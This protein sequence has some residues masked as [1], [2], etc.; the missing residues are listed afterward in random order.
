MPLHY[1]LSNAGRENAPAA[2]RLLLG[3]N[4]A[5]VN[6]PGI[7]RTFS[8]SD[9]VRKYNRL[10]LLS[11]DA[12]YNTTNNGDNDDSNNNNNNNKNNNRN[13]HHQGGGDGGSTA[14]DFSC[15]S[16]EE[17]LQR[18]LKAKPN[19][20]ADFFTALQSLPE[21]LREKAVLIRVVQELLN[22]KIG[23][24]FP[25][26]ILLLDLYLQII[27]KSSLKGIKKK[28]Q[29]ENHQKRQKERIFFT[30]CLFVCLFIL[31]RKYEEEE[32]ES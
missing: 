24:R 29:K 10:V 11:S 31:Y 12:N 26:A 30:G 3:L 32:N 5:L 6:I 9:A 13:H 4:P 18:F 19:P 15:K 7:A 28:T 14:E 27:G 17:C 1:S 20:T 2:V 25:T 8:G 21:S 23:Q 16:V 22:K